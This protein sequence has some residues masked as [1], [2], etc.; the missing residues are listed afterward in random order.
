M[1]SAVAASFACREMNLSVAGF[2]VPGEPVEFG[3]VEICRCAGHVLW[4]LK[5]N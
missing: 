1:A 3:K 4:E 2:D 5:I